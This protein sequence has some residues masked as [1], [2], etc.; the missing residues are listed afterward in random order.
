MNVMN[1]SFMRMMRNTI[2]ISAPFLFIAFFSSLLLACSSGENKQEKAQLPTKKE[3]AAFAA[4]VE[5]LDTA[6]FAGG[7]FWCTEAYFE[8][9]KG[10]K[11]VVSGY[12]G[13]TTP[14]PTYKEVSYGKTDYAEGVQVF[15]DPAQVSYATLVKV[16]FATMDP[17]QLN[18]QGP[19]VGEQYRSIVFPH[20]DRQKEIA[21]AYIQE[22][23][24][25]GQYDKPIVTTIEAFQK[26]YNAEAYHQDYYRRNPSDPYV[27]S[28]ARPKV[29]KFEKEYKEVIKKEFLK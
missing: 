24:E 13:G 7:C 16:F 9:V 19:D 18:R 5:G 4:Q 23:S 15:Y 27:R 26:F 20:N 12:V 28:V 17:T 6:T 21:T 11:E 3:Q 8:R 2:I 29:M 14:N 25:S 22:L 10:V 1:E